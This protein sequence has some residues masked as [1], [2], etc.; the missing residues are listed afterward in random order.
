MTK[1][2]YSLRFEKI[3]NLL[4]CLLPKPLAKLIVPA[5]NA[6]PG[7]DRWIKDLTVEY[8]Y[9]KLSGYY[10]LFTFVLFLALIRYVFFYYNGRFY[11]VFESI[12]GKCIHFV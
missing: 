1:R 9:D 3:G 6:S 7:Y 5:V 11:T 2:G 12:T 4:E 8:Y 10:S